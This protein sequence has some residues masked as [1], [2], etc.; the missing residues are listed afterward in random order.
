MIIGILGND[1]VMVETKDGRMAKDEIKSYV[2][3]RY[4]S[5]SESD[6]KIRQ[7]PISYM[8]PSVQM[9]QFHLPEEQQ[10]IFKEGD[11][12]QQKARR[13]ERT[14]LTEFFRLNRTDE[15]ANDLLYT[16]ILK[17]YTWND[18][19]RCFKERERRENR[20][21]NSTGKSDT[22][23][24]MASIP[25]NAYTSEKFYLRMLLHNVPGPTSFDDLRTVE[26]VT[27]ETFKEA[28]VKRG[29]VEDDKEIEK[30]LDEAY[31]IK[32]GDQFRH[33]FATLMM[34]GSPTSPEELYKAYEVR[35]C[36]DLT[37]E[38]GLSPGKPND[39]VKN[40]C[41]LKLQAIFHDNNKD[42]V[43]DFGL[44]EPQELTKPDELPK[45]I[46]DELSYDILELA[47][48]AALNVKKLNQ[49]QRAVF[50]GVMESVNSESGKMFA[51]D[52]PGGS[53]KTFILDCLLSQARSL[54]KIALAMATTGIAST[55]LANGRTVHTKLK[56]PLKP[57]E[58][59]E[60]P[61]KEKSPFCQLIQSTSLII[62]D[63]VTMG[64][65]LMFECIDRSFR[66]IRKVDKPFGGITVVFS[67]DWRQ[68]LPIVPKGGKSQ[69]LDATLKYS[70][71]WKKIQVFKLTT[72]MRLTSRTEPKVK[73]F[74]E[75]LLKV[76]EGK[77]TDPKDK[78]E[79]PMIRIPSYLK[80]KAKEVN[81]F[82]QEIYPDIHGKFEDCD[83]R[84]HDWRDWLMSKAIICPTNKDAQEINQHMMQQLPGQAFQYFSYDKILNTKNAH[85]Y[86]TEWLN[87][88]EVSSMPPHY[89][90][91]RVGAP[92]MLIRNLDPANGHVNGSRYIIRKLTP[93][94]IYAELATGPKEMIGN[95][96]M[97]PRIIFHP[98]D[99]SLPLEF[100]RKQF[101]IRPCFAMTSNKS[102]GQTLGTVGIYLNN[103][104]FFSHGESI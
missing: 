40:Q 48:Q 95:F 58:N 26:G 28:C 22:I 103:T 54:G 39:F 6:W 16:D 81:E 87:K 71:L 19:S 37:H 96:L 15:R 42:M 35:L 99:P 90:E 27:Y 13:A 30:A 5:G 2:N 65:R 74:S 86:P 53:G 75:Y 104:D 93:H 100:E 69:I 7:Y 43:K 24:R 72:N 11:D 57:D 66:K 33:F 8:Y 25:L 64:N 70:K 92:I 46:S 14:M 17:H 102:Q 21:M 23:G 59:S 51:I 85:N 60:I 68:C 36:E 45:V 55:L 94:V 62:I 52:A 32:F 61:F 47:K 98:E 97:I 3:G 50:D 89:L 49:E 79:L 78:D 31:S 29:L 80:S 77:P 67:G 83:N 82:C 41:L 73:S 91:L 4:I 1:R 84:P 38:E 18:S 76:G 88:Q 44:P 12:L 63:E 10:I 9:L 101:P 20:D 34:Y 56:V